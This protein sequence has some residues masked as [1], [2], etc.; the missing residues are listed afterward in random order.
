MCVG[1]I[2]CDGEGS[3]NDSSML[4]ECSQASSQVS[5]CMCSFLQPQHH[6][7]RSRVVLTACRPRRHTRQCELE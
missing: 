5:T 7:Y 6:L 4:L 1:R 2:C 3:L